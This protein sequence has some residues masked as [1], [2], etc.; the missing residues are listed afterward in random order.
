V[1]ARLF[2]INGATALVTGGSRG[3]GLS[4]A[5]GLVESGATVFISARH[6]E[7]CD[8]AARC[9]SQVGTCVSLP[10]DLSSVDAIAGLAARVGELAP[11]L[12]I[13]VNNAGATWGEPIE[14]FPEKEWDAAL[15]VNLKTPFFLVQ[16]L[17]PLL[18]AAATAENPAR[19]IN[20]GSVAGI[21][22]MA[23]NSYAYAASKAALHHLTKLMARHLAPTVNVNAIAPGAFE[24]RM[25]AWALANRPVLEA[26]VPRGSIGQAD[27]IAGVV[28]FL[29]SRAGAYLTGTV[30]PV[31]GGLS[32][33]NP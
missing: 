17:L 18:Q 9:L 11:S 28:I 30:I 26:Q 20:V 22:P 7:D 15:G 13:L 25:I 23:R 24:T 14:T 21:I 33:R 6:A 12:N 19:V 16:R 29:A 1:N 5:R 10:C 27:D 2:D 3:I 8:A 32:L 4:I 31:D